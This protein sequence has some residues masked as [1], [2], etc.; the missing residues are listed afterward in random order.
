MG[1]RW[2]WADR[3]FALCRCGLGTSLDRGEPFDNIF[4]HPLTFDDIWQVS[5]NISH[6][7]ESVTFGLCIPPA[8]R[9]WWAS[10]CNFPGRQPTRKWGGPRSQVPKASGTWTGVGSPCWLK[11][12]L[13]QILWYTEYTTPSLIQIFQ[14][15]M[16][17]YLKIL[18]TSFLQASCAAPASD[19]E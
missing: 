10:L 9:A 19:S 15:R 1:D 11:R 17:T 3:K 12:W 4:S 16:L 18:C 2:V 7:F 13:G 5:I 14:P 6:W 8:Q